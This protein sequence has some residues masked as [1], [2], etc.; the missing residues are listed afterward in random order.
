MIYNDDQR[1]LQTIC[2]LATPEGFSGIAVVRVSGRDC[3]KI[4]RKLASFLPTDP[5]TH[6][7]YFGVLKNPLSEE[8]IDEVLLSFFSGN[9]SYT[10]EESIEISSHGNPLIVRKIQDCLVQAGA[11]IALPGE[12][13]YRAFR[14]GKID[15]VQAESV[16]GLIHS[17]SE[18]AMKVNL[19]QLQGSLSEKLASLES[20]MLLSLAHIEADIDFSTEN[21]SVFNTDQLL[22]QLRSMQ[23]EITELLQSFAKGRALVSGLKVS[24]CGKPNAGKSSLFNRFLAN[25]RSIVSPHAGTTRDTVEGSIILSGI[26]I[27]FVDT[28]GVHQTDNEIEL[29]GIQRSRQAANEADH[30][31]YVL[32]ADTDDFEEDLVFLNAIPNS[33]VLLVVNKS[34]LLEDQAFFRTKFLQKFFSEFEK[35]RV[36]FVS[37]KKGLVK[38]VLEKLLLMGNIMAHQKNAVLTSS[39]QFEELNQS[40]KFLR[41]AI[42]ILESGKG[43]ELVAMDLKYCLLHIQSIVGKAFDDDVVDTIFKEFCLGK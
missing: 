7:L 37:A 22:G 11:L 12:F 13:T 40:D 25:E 5:I 20:R 33:K 27:N 6:R 30:V 18:G 19:S 9:K 4:V 3:L 10:G 15:L 8:S 39:R 14:N 1:A 41:N 38:E 35:E 23:N 36:L 28:A 32:S 26:R 21:L 2:A 29:L 42:S 24:I 31:I 43:C 17:S 34:D 16:L